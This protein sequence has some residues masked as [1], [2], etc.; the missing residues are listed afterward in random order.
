LFSRAVSFN[1]AYRSIDCYEHVIKFFEALLC[2]SD[3]PERCG[4][5]IALS[6]IDDHKL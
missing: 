1:G 4:G 3:L 5:T 2:V 6:K